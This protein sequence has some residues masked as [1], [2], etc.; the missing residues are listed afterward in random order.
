[1]TIYWKPWKCVERRYWCGF[2][3]DDDAVEVHTDLVRQSVYGRLIGSEQIWERG[4]A[5]T[6]CGNPK[7][8][9]RVTPK[10]LFA[11]ILWE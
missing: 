8:K 7:W 4:A 11:L 1:M 2:E 3:R 5:L 10:F 9:S 6:G